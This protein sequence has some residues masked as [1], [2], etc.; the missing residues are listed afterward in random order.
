MWRQNAFDKIK[1]QAGYFDVLV[2]GGGAT[3]LGIAVD[4]ASRGYSTLLL[5]RD[6]FAKGTSSRS[7]KLAH[8]GVRY[9]AQ[10]N[11]RL[12][13]EALH[14]RGLMRRNAPALVRDLPFIV[15]A[16]QWWEIPFYFIGLKL[17]D[18]L[19]GKLSLGRSEFL[20]V[21]SVLKF[22]PGIR[23]KGLKGGIVYYDGQFD[24]SRMAVSLARTA[25]DHGGIVLNYA[26][27]LELKKEHSGEV[28]RVT[29]RD[30]IRNTDYEVTA[31]NVFNATGVFVDEIYANRE[32][33]VKPLIA[34]SRGSHIVVDGRFLSSLHGLMI[35]RTSD[36]RILFVI[37]WYGQA[38]IGTTDTPVQQ[39]NRE[40][41]PSETEIEFILETAAAYM[42]P[43]PGKND[44]RSVFAGL[45]PLAAPGEANQKTKEISRGHRIVVSPDQMITIIGGK[46]TTYRRMAQDAVDRCIELG[47][48]PAAD[49]QTGNLPVFIS[50]IDQK[51]G[52]GN[53]EKGKVEEKQ[54]TATTDSA[55]PKSEEPNTQHLSP[56]DNNSFAIGKDKMESETRAGRP[57]IDGYPWTE[58]DVKY[59]IREEYA[60]TI[61]DVLSRRLR[62][63]VLDAG[64]AIRIAPVV[65]DI[66][67]LELDPGEYD[68]ERDLTAFL[69]LAKNYHWNGPDR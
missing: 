67:H 54:A 32:D 7:T 41:V 37:P 34:P 27:I 46:W 43:A 3:G 48:L 51:Y 36:G 8:G 38:L 16:Y 19:S 59:V 42:S 68:R 65:A 52:L 58:D 1:N 57:L 25:E 4:A 24:D 13:M 9:L 35:P 61:E 5:E 22:L 60:M 15:P 44:I 2:I 23:K 66:L 33:I 21:S 12:V 14:E 17:Y 62:L 29:F 28:F 49:C 50:E 47:R 55:S 45:R 40:P 18:L 26:E 69:S 64:A 31:R 56:K 6:D 20:S 11:V 10:G 53:K 39:T 30:R 63:L